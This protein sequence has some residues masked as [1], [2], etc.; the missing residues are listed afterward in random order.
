MKRLLITFFCVSLAG[1]EVQPL[2]EVVIER[3]SVD[4]QASRAFAGPGDFPPSG[5]AGYGILAFPVSPQAS[6]DRFKIFCEAYAFTFSTSDDLAARGVT[7]AEQMVTVLPVSSSETA[8]ELAALDAS[9][10]CDLALSEYDVT[11]AQSAI[12]KAEAASERTDGIKS[13]EERGPFLLAWAPG[14]TF[15]SRDAL[16]LV[17][18]L[19]NSATREQAA[20]DMRTWRRDI[21]QD[22]NL[23]RTGWNVEGVRLLAQRWVDRRG[24]AIIKLIGNWG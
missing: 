6:P 7:I 19:S 12:A 22:P 1:C 13:L 3:P 23:W 14:Q 5:F 9:E 18:D 15:G 24:A 20:L 8:F 16:V 2:A 17:A 21:E 11:Q 4:V 10:A